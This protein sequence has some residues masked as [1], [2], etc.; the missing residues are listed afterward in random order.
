MK[1]VSI[2][3]ETTGII[4]EFHQV[5]EFAAVI[6][7]TLNPLPLEKLPKFHDVIRNS[8]NLYSGEAFAIFLNQRIFEILAGK[9]NSVE[10]IR[11]KDL[12]YLFN[13]FLKKNGFEESPRSSQITFHAAGK[14]FGT[15]DKLFLERLPN[16]RKYLQI[17]R[18]VIDPAILYV[19]WEKDEGLP[20][21]ETCKSR[22]GLIDTSISHVA[23]ED[24]LDVIKVLRK[25]YIKTQTQ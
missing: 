20:N 18:R 15:F 2:D 11:E 1:Y 25:T 16:W 8:E 9:D 21:L 13:L 7:D 22:A 3:I 12:A 10:I 6:E 24:A 23:D 5:I 14:C 17:T 19:D 4:P